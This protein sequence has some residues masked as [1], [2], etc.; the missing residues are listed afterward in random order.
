MAS[1]GQWK[2]NV[3]KYTQKNAI[4]NYFRPKNTTSEAK[5]NFE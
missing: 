5:V 4:L 1:R 3:S 2:G